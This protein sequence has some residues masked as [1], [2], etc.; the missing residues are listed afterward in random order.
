MDP[1]L[2]ALF[3]CDPLRLAEGLRTQNVERVKFVLTRWWVVERDDLFR[4]ALDR[5]SVADLT[6]SRTVH[7][8]LYLPQ[9]WLSIGNGSL[10]PAKNVSPARTLHLQTVVL[11]ALIEKGVDVEGFWRDAQTSYGD[12]AR[13]GLPMLRDHEAAYQEMVNAVIAHCTEQDRQALNDAID[14]PQQVRARRRL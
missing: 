14:E 7:G 1:L 6:A 9:W 11:P 12:A 8:V 2:Q 3:D 4:L 13:S 5:L 10:G